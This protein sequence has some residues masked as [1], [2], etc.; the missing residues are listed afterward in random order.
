MAN[1]YRK[2]C[3]IVDS[4]ADRAKPLFVEIRGRNR[5]LWIAVVMRT[6]KRRRQTLATAPF[7]VFDPNTGAADV[8]RR[9]T[10]NG[11][12]P[13]SMCDHGGSWDQEEGGV[14]RC[15]DCGEIVNDQ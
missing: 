1:E 10:L 12:L 14:W 5:D 15:A 13:G 9:L 11:L 8:A 3:A 4:T 2:L 6:G 7:D